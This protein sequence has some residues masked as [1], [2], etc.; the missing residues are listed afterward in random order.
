[1]ARKLA[2]APIPYFWSAEKIYAF[3]DRV[4]QWPVDIVYLG[5]TICA[6][7]RALS[8]QQWF[9]LAQELAETGKEI[10]LSTLALLE[11][12]SDIGM[13]ERIC[14]NHRFPVEA[15]DMAAVQLLAHR[16]PF[17]SGPHINVYN[18]DTLAL[19]VEE[20]A[21][22]W[23]PP[24]ELS[25]AALAQLQATRPSGLETETYVFGRLPLAFSARCFTARAHNI[26]KDQCGF[27]CADYPDGL[28]LRTQEKQPLFTINGIQLQSGVPCNLLGAVHH[29]ISIG[30]EVLR[31][32][33]QSQG[34]EQIVAAFRAALDGELD[35]SLQDNLFH[36]APEGYCNGYWNDSA[37]MV[38]LQ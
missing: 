35:K 34:T 2:L 20:G 4:A 30:V 6:K 11:A 21:Y 22:R 38:W 26:G 9:E 33:P 37:G 19:L 5:E 12:G 13:L 31:I 17:V 28:L 29:L 24:M 27:C 1:M 8:F 25:G 16:I 18:E 3:Y 32:S 7:R 36:W 15:N 23:V 14:N 10:V